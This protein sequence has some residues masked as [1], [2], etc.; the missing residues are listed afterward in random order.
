MKRTKRGGQGAEGWGLYDTGG[1]SEEVREVA[2]VRWILLG[3]RSGGRDILSLT[4]WNSC[5]KISYLLKSSDFGLMSCL[6]TFLPNYRT[7]C[8]SNSF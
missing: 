4:C 1:A 6:V 8:F 2:C 7:I 3:S 5:P